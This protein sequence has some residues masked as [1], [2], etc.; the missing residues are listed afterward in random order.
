[1]EKPIHTG[2]H[3]SVLLFTGGNE[4]CPQWFDLHTAER[5]QFALDFMGCEGKSIFILNLPSKVNNEFAQTHLVARFDVPSSTTSS[6]AAGPPGAA[7][8]SSVAARAGGT[9]RGA[10]KRQTGRG[11]W[12]PS[13]PVSEPPPPPPDTEWADGAK[14]PCFLLDKKDLLMRLRTDI[15]G[16]VNIFAAAHPSSSLKCCR[17]KEIFIQT[18]CAIH[19][20]MVFWWRNR[21]LVEASYAF[22]IADGKLCE[23]NID[24]TINDDLDNCNRE[25]KSLDTSKPL[26]VRVPSLTTAM[27]LNE[28]ICAPDT[29]SA[30]GRGFWWPVASTC[31]KKSIGEIIGVSPWLRPDQ[32]VFRG[33]AG[34]VPVKEQDDA[35]EYIERCEDTLLD[36]SIPSQYVNG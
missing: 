28:T 20:F 7:G 21:S 8:P 9:G 6:R 26:R 12:W 11:F 16:V 24:G 2:D 35:N 36:I 23:A 13:T 1:M 22:M 15:L 27:L 33:T 17:S 10:E 4:P 29:S 25:Q 14:V 31:E 18:P 3:E 5:A 30:E 34:S 19:F 32:S